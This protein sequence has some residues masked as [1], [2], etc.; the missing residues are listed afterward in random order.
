M[1]HFPKLGQ[2]EVQNGRPPDQEAGV[3]LGR[4]LE[5]CVES[6]REIA[7]MLKAHDGSNVLD[8]LACRQKGERIKRAEVFQ[9]DFGAAPPLFPPMNPQRFRRNS[10]LKSQ[11]VH[12]VK[13]MTRAPHPVIDP[14]QMISHSP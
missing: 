7:A 12:M 9:P 11:R 8:L 5:D 1:Y 2:R 10:S 6:A 13:R 4:Q 14:V 3:I